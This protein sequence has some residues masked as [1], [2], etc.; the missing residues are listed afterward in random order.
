MRSSS[1]NKP[2]LQAHHLLI[3][4]KERCEARAILVNEGFLDP[5]I[6]VDD[7]QEIADQQQLFLQFSQDQ[8]Q[9]IM[10]AAFK[11]ACHGSSH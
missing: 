3:V 5:H 10:S 1:D 7:L 2:N 4:F 11:G 9:A 8:I 6:A